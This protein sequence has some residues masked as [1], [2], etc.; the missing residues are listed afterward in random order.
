[1]GP[2]TNTDYN[3]HNI[4][5]EF[6]DMEHKTVKLVESVRAEFSKQFEYVGSQL[7]TYGIKLNIVEKNTSK[8]HVQVEYIPDL[9]KFKK[10]T[11]LQILSV[12]IKLNN[13]EKKL[14][15]FTYKHDKIYLDN[16]LVPGTIGEYCKFKNLKEYIIV[17]TLT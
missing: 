16:L 6:E 14:S 10:E 11:N 7:E 9:N 12:E 1:M 8:D 13:L 4:K 3:N 15:E 2:S 17:I 5:A